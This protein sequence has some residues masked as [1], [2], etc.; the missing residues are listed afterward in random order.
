M[1]MTMAS[2]GISTV[3]PVSIVDRGAVRPVE[4]RG[5]WTIPVG[6]PGAVIMSMVARVHVVL[7]QIHVVSD[8]THAVCGRLHGM[9]WLEALVAWFDFMIGPRRVHPK[10]D[11]AERSNG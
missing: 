10:T 1:T 7:D 9:P 8:V 6:R 4:G 2:P 5:C 11:E 3:P